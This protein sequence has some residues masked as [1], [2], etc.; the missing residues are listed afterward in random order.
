[1]AAITFDTLKFANKLKSAGVPD[2]QA[3]A[4]ALSEALEVNFK[5]LV[6]KE[7]LNVKLQQEFAPIRTDLAVLKWML[8]RND[9]GRYFTGFEGVFLNLG[10]L[11]SVRCH[12]VTPVLRRCFFCGSSYFGSGKS[13]AT[14]T[15][16]SRLQAIASNRLSHRSS[17]A[18]SSSFSRRNS[19]AISCRS[20]NIDSFAASFN[21]FY[22]N[23]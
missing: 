2:K 10:Y 17:S 14:L 1:M 22:P 16:H 7:Y 15:K 9:G 19:S 6:T 11:I 12:A 4:E 5:E 21:M 23:V 18:L 20:S 13:F 3:E 8:G